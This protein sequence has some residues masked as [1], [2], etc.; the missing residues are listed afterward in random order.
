V[1]PEVEENIGVTF[2]GV[3]LMKGLKCIALGRVGMKSMIK[4]VGGGDA[5][6]AVSGKALNPLAYTAGCETG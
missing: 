5:R 4:E 3:W 6:Q 2:S 1:G